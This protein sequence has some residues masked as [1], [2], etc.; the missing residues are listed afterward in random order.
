MPIYL[1]VV[2]VKWVLRVR[3]SSW[4][5]KEEG[6]RW[7]SY[8]GIKEWNL[9]GHSHPLQ[10]SLPFQSSDRN[11]YRSNWRRGGLSLRTHTW[12]GRYEA[13]GVET[14]HLPSESRE[15][16]TALYLTSSCL[17]T[18]GPESS[19]V[20]VSSA[21]AQLFLVHHHRSTQRCVAR[22]NLFQQW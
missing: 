19:V 21:A 11:H 14:L 13:R 10:F 12:W 18:P 22:V 15:H 16:Q 3:G 4:D 1:M 17:F 5:G 8:P 7:C 9:E 2:A 6:R 20:H